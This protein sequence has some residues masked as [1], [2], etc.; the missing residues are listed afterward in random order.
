L[1]NAARFGRV[2]PEPFRQFVIHDRFH[3]RTDFG[4]DELVLGLAGEFRV[5]YL[6]GQDTGQAFAR[7]VPRHGDFLFLADPAFPG[8]GVDLAG[9][10][11]A[12]TGQMGAPIPLGDVIGETQH[13]F[14][15]A[16]IPLHRAFNGQAVFL[17]R[18]EN[19]IAMQALAGSVQPFHKSLH[20]AVIVQIDDLLIGRAG[21]RQFDIDAGI[22]E[23]QFPQPVFQRAEIK[24]DH[25]EGFLR[26]HEGDLCPLRT[27]T[28]PDNLQRL[29][30]IAMLKAHAIDI[31]A[32]LDFQFQ[33][34]RQGVHHGNANPMQTARYFIGILV[35]LPACMQLG[36][37]DL[38][39]RNAFGRVQFGGDAA[40]I[41]RHGDGSITIQGDLDDIAMTR[42]RLVNRI[43]DDFI[44]H[45]MQPGAV[46][47][48]PDIHARPFAHGFQALQDLDGVCAIGVVF[49][50]DVCLIVA[51]IGL[52]LLFI[53]N[54]VTIRW[55]GPVP[56]PPRNTGPDPQRCQRR[57][58]PS[59]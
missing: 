52:T 6:Y 11:A 28:G 39:R 59:L 33:P 8:I 30:G 36:H 2:F 47:G 14:V 9:Q 43:V 29:H 23:G 46:I 54:S 37:D 57:S 32:A 58:D 12:E 50:L 26:R 15:I 31:A 38:C 34:G 5:R 10:R 53:I 24:F 1:N 55:G 25:G 7:I 56:P 27:T 3:H 22:Q 44:D 41:I 4:G 45:M 40:T 49:A 13:V 48:V 16:V 21:I 19:R 51:H 17:T 20:A 35:E 42:Q 18:D